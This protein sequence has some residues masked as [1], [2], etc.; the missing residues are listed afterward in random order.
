MS[1][2]KAVYALLKTMR[3]I[4]IDVRTFVTRN[5]NIGETSDD[6]VRS[7]RSRC[8]RAA[9]HVRGE[10]LDNVTTVARLFIL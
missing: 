7:N 8:P 2:K 6:T 4:P 9:Y 10:K 1:G 3:R 5:Y